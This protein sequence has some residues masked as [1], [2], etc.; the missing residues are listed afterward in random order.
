MEKE[1]KVGEAGI[2]RKEMDERLKKGKLE[3]KLYKQGQE[4]GL[5]GCERFV[6]NR[7]FCLHPAPIQ[8]LYD[9][10]G[11]YVYLNSINKLNFKNHYNKQLRHVVFISIDA[12]KNT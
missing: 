9:E 3:T 2:E 12:K 11:L 4:E 5:K 1:I 8:I 10:Y 6:T 7:D